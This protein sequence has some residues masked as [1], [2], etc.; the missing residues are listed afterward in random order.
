MN[1]NFLAFYMGHAFSHAVHVQHHLEPKELMVPFVAYWQEKQSTVIPYPAET[2]AEAVEKA[3]EAREQSAIGTTGWA[4]CREA[5]VQQP[6]GAKLNTLLVEGWN[7]GLTPQLEMFV[8]CRKEPFKLIRG[9]FW[10]P[11]PD[12]RKNAQV[13]MGH[14]KDGILSHPFGQKSIEYVERAEPIQFVS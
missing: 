12:A 14:F 13:F 3:C 8:Y 2:Q 5:L 4:S 1:E 6:D 7:P 9:F 11:H 10:K